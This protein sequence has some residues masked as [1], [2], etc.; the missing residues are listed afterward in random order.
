MKKKLVFFDIDGTLLPHGKK[1]IAQDV[2][3]GIK[4]VMDS[5]VEVFICTGRCYHQASALINQIGTKNHICSNGQEVFYDGQELYKN[6]FKQ[7]DVEEIV[8]LLNE[9]NVN[10]AFET[11]RNLMVPEGPNNQAVKDYFN[12]QNFNDL[13]TNEDVLNSEI[14]QFW[15]NGSGS[16]IDDLLKILTEKFTYY[17][18]NDQLFEILPGAENK[19]KG[20][21]VINDHLLNETITYAFGDG[22][23]DIEML[24][25]VDESVA[26]GNA[27]E[28]VKEAAKHVTGN[29]NDDGIINGL[30]MVGLLPCS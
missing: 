12:S 10:W 5:G 1:E 13:N 23:N 14:F 25:Y 21:K 20:I 17:K 7:S 26:M 30:K 22:V 2:V 19:A 24:N 27:T 9:F 6:V 16:K 8:T 3:D 18:W 11:R 28:R 15:I 4:Q 29:T